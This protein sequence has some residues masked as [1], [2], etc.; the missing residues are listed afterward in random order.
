M[1]FLETVYLL[2]MKFYEVMV[3]Y[4]EREENKKTYK[5]FL[6][7]FKRLRERLAPW[8][9]RINTLI[10]FTMCTQYCFFWILACRWDTFES[11]SLFWSICTKYSTFLCAILTA[12]PPEKQQIPDGEQ[13]AA[14]A[15]G[16][17]RHEGD[18]GHCGKRRLVVLHTA[19]LQAA[20]HRG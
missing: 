20:L 6:K 13:T 18:A 9:Q 16:E 8:K 3:C 14:R 19:L 12:P 7:S 10:C 11:T 5:S 17:E 15:V 2:W 4:K 1:W